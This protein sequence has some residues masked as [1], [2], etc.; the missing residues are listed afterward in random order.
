MGEI[1]VILAEPEEARPY[2]ANEGSRGAKSTPL[3]RYQTVLRVLELY[4]GKDAEAKAALD[5]SEVRDLVAEEFAEDFCMTPEGA[6]KV[7]GDCLHGHGL[8]AREVLP[9]GRQVVF[10][11]KTA[12]RADSMVFVL[13]GL[14]GKD[15]KRAV[16]LLRKTWQ[17]E[18]QARLEP[19]EQEATG[20]GV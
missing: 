3:A 14:R 20:D 17:Q 7:A 13:Q 5:Y 19:E 11:G 8:L 6:K 4:G 2:Q 15:Q 16:G 9:D 10:V 1:E 18:A 12:S